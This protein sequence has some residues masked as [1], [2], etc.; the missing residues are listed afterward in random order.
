MELDGSERIS[1]YCEYR[2]SEIS[3]CDTVGFDIKIQTHKPSQ[4]PE[5]PW[6]ASLIYDIRGVGKMAS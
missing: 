3:R 5:A 2:E 4:V 6:R 1:S